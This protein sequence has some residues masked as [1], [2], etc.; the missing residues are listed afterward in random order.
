MEND[1]TIKQMIEGKFVIGSGSTKK[2]QQQ[3]KNINKKI[4]VLDLRKNKKAKEFNTQSAVTKGLERNKRPRL[5]PQ[6][7]TKIKV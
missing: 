4:Y 6:I 1:P 5:R 7:W 3:P 2:Q